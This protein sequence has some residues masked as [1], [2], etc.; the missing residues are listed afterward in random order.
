MKLFLKSITQ[1]T[2]KAIQVLTDYGFIMPVFASSGYIRYINLFLGY[3]TISIQVLPQEEPVLPL[4]RRHSVHLL[5]KTNL[6]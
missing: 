1:Y 6:S 5:C 2:R 4:I 3:E